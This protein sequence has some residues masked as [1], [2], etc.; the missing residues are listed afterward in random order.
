MAFSNIN[1]H[2]GSISIA[3]LSL[4][5]IVKKKKKAYMPSE[6]MYFPAIFYKFGAIV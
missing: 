3:L 1:M 5:T 2:T 4:N 6:K